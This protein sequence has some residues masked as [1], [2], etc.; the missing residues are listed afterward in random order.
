[1]KHILNVAKKKYKFI[2][3][4]P[5]IEMLKTD[6]RS[7]HKKI[8][9]PDQLRRLLDVAEKRAPHVRSQLILGAATGARRGEV[10][11]LKFCDFNLSIPGNEYV[12]IVSEPDRK[13]KTRRENR[14]ELPGWAVEE[15]RY[16]WQWWHDPLTGKRYERNEGQRGYLF[17][18]KDGSPFRVDADTVFVL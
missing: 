15:V 9:M 12:I 2:K 11:R 14:V 5:D 10:M 7:I 8:L 3:D 1:M 13:R 4:I 18:K 16:L 17:C 6:K